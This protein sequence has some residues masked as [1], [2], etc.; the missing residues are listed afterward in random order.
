M[1]CKKVCYYYKKA[2]GILQ[3]FSEL[4]FSCGIYHAL[5]LGYCLTEPAEAIDEPYVNTPTNM[6]GGMRFPLTVDEGCIFVLGD[7]RN[8]SRDSRYTEIGQVREEEVLGKV[9]FLFLPG[10]NGEDIYGD[11]KEPRDWTRIGVIK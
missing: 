2:V 9:V 8:V 10:T 7:N 6:N 4:L 5:Q 1:A 3:L 11:P